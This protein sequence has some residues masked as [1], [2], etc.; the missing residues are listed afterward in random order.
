MDFPIHV[1]RIRIGLCIITFKGNP[2]AVSY[3]IDIS[4][5]FYFVGLINENEVLKDIC[6]LILPT[7]KYFKYFAYSLFYAWAIHL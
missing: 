5:C 1:D 3:G 6:Y 2:I 4:I 7:L